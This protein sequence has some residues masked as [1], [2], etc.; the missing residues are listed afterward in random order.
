MLT[1][2]NK[3]MTITNIFTRFTI[4]IT[5]SFMKTTTT[6]TSR[7]SRQ[8]SV[9]PWQIL[10]TRAVSLI[11]LLNVYILEAFPRKANSRG[12][13]L[14]GKLSKLTLKKQP[15]LFGCR[16]SLIAAYWVVTAAHLVS[17]PELTQKGCCEPKTRE[18][19]FFLIG[20]SSF[21]NDQREFNSSNITVNKYMI[22]I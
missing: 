1:I 2:I 10:Q 4:T 6:C 13:R 21:Q 14:C 16:A 11:S 8:E 18:N 12:W 17:D 22:S 3:H 7:K 5:N 20:Q 9:M 15:Q 19:F